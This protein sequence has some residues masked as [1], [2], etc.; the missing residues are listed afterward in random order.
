MK[1]LKKE[2]RQKWAV[3]YYCR[4]PDFR[5]TVWKSIYGNGQNISQE[6]RARPREGPD[7]DRPDSRW[8]P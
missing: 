8:K 5:R 2:E 6:N 3:S 4:G 1:G 7:V